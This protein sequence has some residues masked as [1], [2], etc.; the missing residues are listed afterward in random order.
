M[1]SLRVVKGPSPDTENKRFLGQI[2]PDAMG[3][4]PIPGFIDKGT[5]NDIWVGHLPRGR[6]TRGSA[7]QQG[8]RL[9]RVTDTR[10][11]RVP[12]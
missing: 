2:D 11:P 4:L 1:G 10:E 12:R 3:A 9:V 5:L 7:A 8:W 6:S